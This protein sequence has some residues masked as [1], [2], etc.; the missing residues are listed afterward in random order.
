MSL[1]SAFAILLAAAGAASAQVVTFNIPSEPLS[2]ALHDY[3][4]ESG[5]QVI[6]TEDLVQGRTS[7]E[8][9]GA[10]TP[11][12]ALTLLLDGAG[13]VARPRSTGAVMIERG[14][15]AQGI[16]ESAN[17]LAGR[18]RGPTANA[19]TR[20]ILSEVLVTA[21]KRSE[22]LLDV[23]ASISAIGGTELESLQVNTL[24][25][26]AG[27]TPGLSVMNA[28]APGFRTLVI[29]RSPRSQLRHRFSAL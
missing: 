3:G 10:L 13:L 5:R 14:T 29:R 28:G 21:E 4:Q 23:P 6:V 19:G 17:P 11:D 22:N 15:A 12:H 18:T 25:D 16:R 2:Q 27:Y 24:S 7:R 9:R 26:L 20:T 1:R 8:V